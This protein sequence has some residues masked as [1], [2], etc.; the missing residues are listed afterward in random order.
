MN[1]FAADFGYAWVDLTEFM[2]SNV[3]EIRSLPVLKR[4]TDLASVPDPEKRQ[5]SSSRRY[6]PAPA[7]PSAH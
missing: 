4:Q 6:V 7:P 1:S 2:D 5:F 3:E